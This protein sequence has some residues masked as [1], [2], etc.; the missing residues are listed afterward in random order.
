MASNG[1]PKTFTIAGRKWTINYVP[2]DHPALEGDAIGCC[3]AS[4]SSIWVS[5]DQEHQSLVDTLVHEL[6][7]A[8]YS[9]L[10]FVPH[11][12]EEFEENIVLLATQAFFEIVR[13]SKKPFWE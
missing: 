7:H 11:D 4:T 10:P 12:D 1:L 6:M 5:T 9:S 3:E 2:E 13:N 8:Y